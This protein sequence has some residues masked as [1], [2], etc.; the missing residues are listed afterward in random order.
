MVVFSVSISAH[1]ST[2][3]IG[4]SP[5][6]LQIVTLSGV[7][8]LAMDRPVLICK[9]GLVTAEGKTVESPFAGRPVTAADARF[10]RRAVVVEGTEIWTDNRSGW[11]RKAVSS[12]RVNCLTWLDDERLLAGLAEARVG[13]VEDEVIPVESFDAVPERSTWNTPWGGPP[14]VR[15]FA[16]SPDGAVYANIHVG[17]IV[18]SDDGG[19]SWTSITDG[20]EK[21]V[22]QV[23]AHP[24]YPEVVFAATARGFHLSVDR[25]AHFERRTEPMPYYYQR[26]CAAFPGTETYLCS[27]SRGPHGEAEAMLFRSED[28]GR[29]WSRAAD[30]PE[31]IPSNIDTYQLTAC[32]DGSAWVVV[33]D[34]EVWESRD[35][36]VT[37]TEIA[38]RLPKVY[39][40]L[41][42]ASTD[43][44]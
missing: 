19:T 29:T 9:D 21:D 6:P 12:A 1:C 10:G 7:E 13:F 34:T 40:F 17:W 26:A 27:T 39:G 41:H 15:S 37:W 25:G 20:L 31:H 43:T 18:R 42:D 14:D 44:I 2:P 4:N 8:A 24:D 33:S 30:L 23:A 5:V 3:E 11:I 35:Y 32:S 22:H 38:E 16:L 36:G 28:S